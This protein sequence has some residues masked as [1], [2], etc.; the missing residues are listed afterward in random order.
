MA[1]GVKV[2]FATNAIEAPQEPQA[3]A[4][5]ELASPAWSPRS[6]TGLL[7]VLAMG[8]FGLA[9]RL[10]YVN[11]MRSGDE[12]HYL[13]FNVALRKYHSLNPA[14]AYANGDYLAI[15]PQ[16]IEPHLVPGPDAQPLPLHGFGGPLLWHPFYLLMG[17]AGVYLF[18]VLVSTLTVL[19]IYWLLSE[20]GFARAYAV[21]VAGLFAVGTPL[22]TYSS[23]LFIEPIAALAVVFAVRGLLRAELTS[24]RIAAV[25]AA[26]GALVWVHGRFLLLIVPVMLLLAGRIWQ[27]SRFRDRWAIV[28]MAV[29]S[30]LLVGG[31]AL[32][33]L[34]VWGTANPAPANAASG[35]GIF[36]I[37]PLTGVL[38]ALLDRNYGLLTNFPLMFLVGGGV[39]LALGGGLRRTSLIV[40][41]VVV[42]Y[43]VAVCTFVNWWAG[44]GPP[45]RYLVAVAPL[46]SI[47]VAVVLRQL[48]HW[49]AVAAAVLLAGYGLLLGLLSDIDKGLRWNWELH[50]EVSVLGRLGDLL[51]LPLA[52]FTPSA[53]QPGQTALFVWWSA[54]VVVVSGLIWLAGNLH[55]LRR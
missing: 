16:P 46:L 50:P 41:A 8:V 32:Y 43:S 42:P 30:V 25:A 26:M 17:V 21:G 38:N 3:T 4:T 45:A 28:A 19:N 2:S 49:L 47:F 39:L 11:P 36:Q 27:R 54:A 10:R 14:R 51:G 22:Y 44:F 53:F 18:M 1:Y 6:W 48:N 29:P 55:R 35:N 5:V 12:P 31:Y 40:A 13:M 15:H 52:T 9:A 7:A 20:L 37:S 34:V 33:N 23:M 24:A